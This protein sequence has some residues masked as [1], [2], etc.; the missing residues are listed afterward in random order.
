MTSFEIYIDD[1]RYQVPQVVFIM[2][3]DRVAAAQAAV[4]MMHE[5]RH[6]RGVELRRD[7][8]R[9]FAAGSFAKRPRAAWRDDEPRAC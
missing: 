9:I 8:E 6:Y 4:T 7:D 1:E 3:G 5:N 2:A